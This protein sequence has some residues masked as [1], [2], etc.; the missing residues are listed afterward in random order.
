MSKPSASDRD[1][2]R[3]LMLFDQPMTLDFGASAGQQIFD[4]LKRAILCMDLP[5]GTMISETDVGRH[6][7]A[8]RTPVRE[9]FMQLREAGL[10]TTWPSRGNYVAK[11]SSPRIREARF[12]REALE[13]ATITTL[14]ENGLPDAAQ[15]ELADIL[16]AQRANLDDA[17]AFQ[18]LDDQ[19][20][21]A[22]AMATGFNRA[23]ELLEREKMVLDRLR[24]LSLDE[25]GHKQQLLA[26]HEAIL[27]AIVAGDAQTARSTMTRHLRG[28]LITLAA[29]TETHADY[30]A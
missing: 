11:L 22:L 1:A 6:F 27:D 21:I 20:H 8:S 30:F 2:K 16:I 26:E 29:L 12:I 19:F 14:C 28:I 9:A 24:V 13:L 7:A 25:V 17:T 15:S 23:G 4:V 3:P 10:V 18:N 5:P